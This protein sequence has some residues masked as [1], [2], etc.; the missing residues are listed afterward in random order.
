M[1][2]C[3][4]W[5][6]SLQSFWTHFSVNTIMSFI[7]NL[8][9]WDFTWMLSLNFF[10]DRKSTK[11][12]KLHFERSNPAIQKINLLVTTNATCESANIFYVLLSGSTNACS[13]FRSC[14]VDQSFNTTGTCV[15]NC[16]CGATTCDV[17]M[18]HLAYKPINFQFTFCQ[19]STT[20]LKI[21]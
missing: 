12:A 4:G 21:P 8:V 1:C 11:F 19:I 17:I 13:K 15:I 2:T 5:E 20:F 3:G 6:S 16:D 14:H 18:Q 9:F 10:S 7:W